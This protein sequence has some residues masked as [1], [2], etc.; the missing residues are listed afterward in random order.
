[1]CLGP[2]AGISLLLEMYD[3]LE[4]HACFVHATHACI[5]HYCLKLNPINTLHTDQMMVRQ[6][7][8]VQFPFNSSGP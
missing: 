8:H 3:P 4:Y 6:N 2:S 5:E 7:G 1:M